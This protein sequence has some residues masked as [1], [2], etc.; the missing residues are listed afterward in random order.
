PPLAAQAARHLAALPWV[1]VRQ[2]NGA[3][4]D[5]PF[6]AIFVNAGVTHPLDAWL[7]ALTPGGRL[8]LPLTGGFPQMGHLR[9]GVVVLITERAGGKYDAQVTCPMIS[10]YSAVGL[11][12]AALNG[13]LGRAFQ[14]G[15]F[16]RLRTF[17]RDPHDETPSC[18][19][20]TSRFCF[21]A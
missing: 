15:P 20:H 17:R 8:A 5:G 12:D 1:D 13:V 2:D 19:Y 10:I 7:D 6:D 16:V 3:A 14:R 11:R 4:V 18:W 9:K 21:E